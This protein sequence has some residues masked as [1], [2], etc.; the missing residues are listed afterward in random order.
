MFCANLLRPSTFA[1]PVNSLR[2]ISLLFLTRKLPANPL[3]IFTLPEERVAR[4]S[5]NHIVTRCRRPN[6]SETKSLTN[7]TAGHIFRSFSF[8]GCVLAF[9]SIDPRRRGESQTRP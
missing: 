5:L 2:C 3:I 6:L 7:L 4:S 1:C 9:L 8:S